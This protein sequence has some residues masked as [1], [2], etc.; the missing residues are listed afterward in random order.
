MQRLKNILASFFFLIT[1]AAFAQAP[2]EQISREI[3]GT[4][5]NPKGETLIGVSLQ[6]AD[7]YDGATS[8][9]DGIFSFKT[10]AQDSQTLVI[11]Y[12]GYQE[13]YLYLDMN[14]SE[15]TELKITYKEKSIELDEIIIKEVREFKSTDKARTTVLGTI[16]VLSVAA[17]GDIQ[18]AFK[19]FP[20]VQPVAESGGL[21]IRGG[22]NEET[23]TFVDGMRIDK[24]TYTSPSNVNAQSRF[25]PNMFKGMYLSSGNYSALY[26]QA[27][28]SALILETEDLPTKSSVD[29][30]I[31]PLFVEVGGQLLSKDEKST[32]GATLNYTNGALV[33]NNFPTNIGFTKPQEN[34]NSTY[35]YKRKMGEGGMLKYYGSLSKSRVGVLQS[36]LNDPLLENETFVKNQ[37][38]FNQFT[39]NHTFESDW[40][41]SLG[42]SYSRN[43]DD[44]TFMN[45]EIA[46]AEIISS[47]NI[48]EDADVF[49]LR[50]VATR[51]LRKAKLNFGGEYEYSE[52]TLVNSDLGPDAIRV[53]DN[54]T[55]LF[56]EYNRAF[57]NHLTLSTGLRMEHYSILDQTAIMPRFTLTYNFEKNTLLYASWGEFTQKPEEFF[58]YQTTDLDLQRSEQYTI[59]FQKS[60]NYQMLRLEAFNKK[61]KNLLKYEPTLGNNGY[62]SARGV[63]LYWKDKKTFDIFEYWLSYSLLDT[64]RNYLDYPIEAQPN[65][66]M[67]HVASLTLK[68]FIPKIMTN[69][70]ATYTYGSGR[71]YYNPNQASEEFMSDR[72]IDYHNIN[73]NVAY[74]PKIKNTFSVV[75]LTISNVIGNQQI[76]NYEYAQNDFSNRR[77]VRPFIKR[78]VFLGFFVNL[79]LDRTDNIINRQLN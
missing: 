50:T 30:G 60:N 33:L 18:T 3:K 25:S 17:D 5:F 45:K 36:D 4:V 70:G 12:F 13:E 75:V 66:A 23:Q 8:D 20:G 48:K 68:K 24:F 79:G 10:T 15:I 59:G 44:Y 53:R 65:F 31:S 67:K 57:T 63:E 26:G 39:Y 21:F 42:T 71:P 32:G 11:S 43:K 19:T 58:L 74:L 72:T 69:I 41:L 73:F 35:N 6:I 49:Q 28:S 77:A 14:S 9:I 22:T 62:G 34:I 52:N 76:F 47:S 2:A 56:G 61:Y 7:T 38:F 1:L 64:K 27:I 16:D 54:Y 29:F 40:A 51:F 37:N 55:A 78:L 46:D